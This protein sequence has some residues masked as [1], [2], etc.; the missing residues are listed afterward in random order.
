MKKILTTAVLLSLCPFAIAQHIDSVSKNQDLTKNSTQSLSAIDAISYSLEQEE[1]RLKNNA[2]RHIS[3]IPEP[4]VDNALPKKQLVQQEKF[5]TSEKIIQKSKSAPYTEIVQETIKKTSQE[6]RK[7]ETL[8][9]QKEISSSST[10]NSNATPANITPANV[11]AQNAKSP[12]IK[13]VG[14]TKKKK[15]SYVANKKT[16]KK[17]TKST[18]TSIAKTERTTTQKTEEIS[19]TKIAIP[20]QTSFKDIILSAQYDKQLGIFSYSFARKDGYPVQLSDFKNNHPSIDYYVVKSNLSSIT[21]YNKQD[22][23]HVNYSHQFNVSGKCEA[24]YVKYYMA[25]DEQAVTQAFLLDSVGNLTSSFDNACSTPQADKRETVF[26]SQDGHIVSLDASSPKFTIKKP[27]KLKAI[28]NHEGQEIMPEDLSLYAVSSDFT[29]FYNM[30]KTATKAAYYGADFTHSINYPSTYFF[31]MS[32][33]DKRNN[34][35]YIYKHS[36]YLD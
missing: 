21:Q 1:K 19:F 34:Y 18:V 17:R 30:D 5:Y 14:V 13:K 20:L 35:Q 10:V 24:I 28:I 23:T 4:I 22:F 9:T 15:N 11:I 27:I 31:Y 7:T 26:Y 32:F 16:T 3:N 25:G 36:V 12:S 2:A 29:H 8:K 33:S 6:T